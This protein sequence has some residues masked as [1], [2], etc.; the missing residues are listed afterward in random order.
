MVFT[1]L[2]TTAATANAV[3]VVTSRI[4]FAMARDGLLPTSLALVNSAGAPWAALVVSALLLAVVAATG[5]VPFAAAAGGFLY[6]L[7]FVVPLVALIALRRRGALRASAFR[8]P[9]PRLI[10]PLAFLACA[11]LLVASGADGTAGGLSWLA[12]GAL[13]YRLAGQTQGG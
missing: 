11:V 2:L 6:V 7:H 9:R 12:L 4:S 8:T 13:G 3:L 1:A 10:L 5:S